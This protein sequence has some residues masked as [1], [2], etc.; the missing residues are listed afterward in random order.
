VY[1]SVSSN[2]F[3]SS[4]CIKTAEQTES[5]DAAASL[6]SLG[7]QQQKQKLLH[8]TTILFSFH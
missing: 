6:F 7:A 2:S 8:K 5:V 1:S 3:Y 4:N